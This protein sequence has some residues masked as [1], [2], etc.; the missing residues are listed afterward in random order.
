MTN[1]N[2]RLDK[3]LQSIRESNGEISNE[4]LYDLI[5]KSPDKIKRIIKLNNYCS[6]L[7]DSFIDDREFSFRDSYVDPEPKNFMKYC[8]CT[9]LGVESGISIGSA[10]RDVERNVDTS[11]RLYR[12]DLKEY[13]AKAYLDSGED[14]EDEAKSLIKQGIKPE[15]IL[16]TGDDSG[17]ETFNPAAFAKDTVEFARTCGATELANKLNSNAKVKRAK[18]L[19]NLIVIL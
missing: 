5:K 19:T 16:I 18:E 11:E 9:A 15:K 4:E 10:I 8:I 6:E 7:L 12:A 2:E 14:I 13:S 1:L 17:D 3:H